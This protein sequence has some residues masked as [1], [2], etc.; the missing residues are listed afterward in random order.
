M[1]SSLDCVQCSLRFSGE[2]IQE[3]LFSVQIRLSAQFAF[4]IYTSLME[5]EL[6]E[7]E[8]IVSQGKE[9]TIDFQFSW[10]SMRD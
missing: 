2:N 4:Y 3:A 9:K 10:E 1:R 8:F 7:N 5:Y 6:W